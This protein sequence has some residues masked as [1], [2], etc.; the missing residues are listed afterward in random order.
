MEREAGFPT[1]T[2]ISQVHWRVATYRDILNLSSSDLAT[3][4]K[5]W[6]NVEHPW[7]LLVPSDPNAKFGWAFSRTSNPEI[8]EGLEEVRIGHQQHVH[9]PNCRIVNKF[10][11]L[12]I[13][14]EEVFQVHIDSFIKLQLF[15][16]KCEKER[17]SVILNISR[18]IKTRAS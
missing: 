6:G 18:K 2:G 5:A 13:A 3:R 1:E 16:K 14:P 15:N 4:P 9:K 11:V 7:C 10:G 17:P 12:Q 8:Q